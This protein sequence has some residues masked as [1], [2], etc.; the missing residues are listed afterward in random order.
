MAYYYK[1]KTHQDNTVRVDALL[2]MFDELGT[3]E[4]KRVKMA[5]PEAGNHVI[6]CE[7]TSKSYNEVLA[8]TIK[9][10]VG[11]LKIEPVQK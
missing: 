8:E 10:A 7:L 2:E 9:F 1:D 4:S 11:I 5:F 3:A 6:G